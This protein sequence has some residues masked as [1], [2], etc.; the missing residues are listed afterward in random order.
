M[1]MKVLIFTNVNF[2]K[3]HIYPENQ[4]WVLD[5]IKKNQTWLLKLKAK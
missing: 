5:K 3:D 2:V 1:F 4:K